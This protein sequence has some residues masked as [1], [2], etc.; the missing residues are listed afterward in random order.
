MAPGQAPAFTEEE[1]GWSAYKVRLEAYFQA[2]E[3]TD[4]A[5]Q[6]AL[7]VAALSNG[8]VKVLQGRCH[9]KSVND[10]TYSDVIKHLQSHYEPQVNETAASYRFFTRTQAEGE[11]LRDFVAALRRMAEDCNFGDMW[12]RM[13]RDRIV[14]GV[15]DD[16]VR[17]LLLTRGSLTLKEAEDFVMAAEAATENAQHMQPLPSP[18][19][20]TTN[21]V[22]PGLSRSKSKK[23]SGLS[24]DEHRPCTRC[25]ASSHQADDCRHLQTVCHRC[26]KRSHLARVCRASDEDTNQRQQANA[27]LQDA[28]ESSE[29]CEALYTLTAHQVMDSAHVKPILRQISWNGVPP[30][31]LVDTG[32]PVSV[33]P[34]S[35]FE[36]HQGEWPRLQA[37]TMK[38]SCFKAPLPINGK[39]QLNATMSDA[40]IQAEL[41]VIDCPGPMLCGRD[42]IRS[43]NTAGVPVLTG[44]EVACVQA[45]NADR[46]VETMLSKYSDVF[47]PGLGLLRGPPVH[48][49]V[50]EGARPRFCKARTVPYALKQMVSA[51]LDRL[52]NEGALSPVN[53]PNGPH[54]WCP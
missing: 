42:T 50:K 52:V 4:E 54:P 23:A 40:T 9:P 29:D 26:R 20:D 36:R 37:T 12:H 51:E 22:R 48:L 17:R 33:I 39:L 11:R 13:L 28:Q 43:F 16:D 19:A 21:F 47:P 49:T 25:G 15:R 45:E 3:I 31:M 38:L 2:Q 8:A 24:R 35:V 41:F 7:L 1:G 32:S 14:C 27:L 34:R 46:M 5:K 10:L 18:V 6:R 44:N 53:R 30:T